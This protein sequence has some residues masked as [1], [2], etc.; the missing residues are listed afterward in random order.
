MDLSLLS[1]TAG[2]LVPLSILAACGVICL[3]HYIGDNDPGWKGLVANIL[4]IVGGIAVIIAIWV[5][6]ASFI[7]IV[8]AISAVLF[9]MAPLFL[10]GGASGVAD[11]RP[12][13]SDYY[14]DP[15]RYDYH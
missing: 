12:R 3:V 13:R 8:L 1:D 6:S 14:R 5:V 9:F 11:R 10:L 4:R 7:A 15:Y 2:P